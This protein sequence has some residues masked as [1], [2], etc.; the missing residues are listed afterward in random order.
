M[1]GS[2]GGALRVFV[3][4]CPRSGTTLVQGLLAAHRAAVSFPESHFFDKNFLP[5]GF[6]RYRVRAGAGRSLREFAGRAGLG[7]M[8]DALPEAGGAA[9]GAGAGGVRAGG[10]RAGDGEPNHD[11]GSELIALL[12]RAAAERGA[13]VWVEKTPD[14]VFRVPL[15]LRVAPDAR[16]VHVVRRGEDVVRSLRRA[17]REWGRPRSWTRCALHWA[18]AVRVTARHASRPG[19]Y[20]I[21][22]SRLVREP[23]REMRGLLE[24]LGL[25]W[26]GDLL[27]RY[28]EAVGELVDPGETWK[29]ASLAGG[30]RATAPSPGAPLPAPARWIVRAA[31]PAYERL[32]GSSGS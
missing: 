1:S 31:T 10:G 26:Q 3:V 15:I 19:H 18:A 16:F 5:L 4:G 24:W 22:Y 30:V 32:A 9:G 7:A 25:P 23:E 11:P 29:V 12:D 28:G 21:I 14:H 13:S 6:G 17:T 20:I 27:E 2:E 8:Y